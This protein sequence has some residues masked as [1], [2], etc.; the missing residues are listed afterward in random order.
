MGNLSPKDIVRYHKGSDPPRFSN[1]EERTKVSPWGDTWNIWL[2]GQDKNL[3]AGE[4]LLTTTKI[5]SQIPTILEKVNKD[6]IG[7]KLMGEK[8]SKLW[9]TEYL[10]G[11]NQ[12]KLLVWNHRLNHCFFITSSEC[13]RRG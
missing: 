11:Q 7:S 6:A 4:Y 5:P 2:L 1:L 10:L 9:S 13:P 12:R 8:I 3:E